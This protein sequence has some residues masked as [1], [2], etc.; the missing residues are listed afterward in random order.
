MPSP[1]GGLELLTTGTIIPNKGWVQSFFQ[2][3]LYGFAPLGP[4]L[5]WMFN[6]P[7]KV[8]FNGSHPSD[9]SIPVQPLGSWAT[10]LKGL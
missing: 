10:A 2:I 5:L 3:S 8:I 4:L 6:Y 1:I 7:Y 9:W